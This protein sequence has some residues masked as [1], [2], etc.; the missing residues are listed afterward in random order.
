[1]AIDSVGLC[2]RPPL[3][4]LANTYFYHFY[5]NFNI[6]ISRLEISSNVMCN[7]K[8]IFL[9]IDDEAQQAPPHASLSR[10][11]CRRRRAATQWVLLLLYYGLALSE[12]S[13]MR[14][15]NIGCTVV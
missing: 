9:E 2:P 13:D 7:N 14:A 1:M 6:K 5:K 3:K 12:Q 8:S 4:Q 10:F 15:G 11:G